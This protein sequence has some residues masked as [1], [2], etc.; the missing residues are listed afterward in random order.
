MPRSVLLGNPHIP[1]GN[2]GQCC[3]WTC[4]KEQLFA[5]VSCEAFTQR[6]ANGD[7]RGP[8]ITP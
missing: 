3:E 8:V 1:L 4:T 5:G 6:I 7:V 2:W